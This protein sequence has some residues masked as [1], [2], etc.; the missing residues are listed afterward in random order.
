MKF[1]LALDSPIAPNLRSPLFLSRF[2]REGL[3]GAARL[4]ADSCGYVPVGRAG[5]VLVPSRI[6]RSG[7]VGR[8]STAR[9]LTVDFSIEVEEQR[10]RY[11][12]KDPAGYENHRGSATGACRCTN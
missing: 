10:L 4:P 9:I 11:S 7:Q 5:L 8:P 3:S 6:G 12:T 1:L 2:W